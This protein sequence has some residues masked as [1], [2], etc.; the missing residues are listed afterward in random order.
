[1]KDPNGAVI[2]GAT[3]SLPARISCGGRSNPATQQCAQLTVFGSGIAL[4]GTQGSPLLGAFPI[5]NAPLP[6]SFHNL[7]S[8]VG[9]YPVSE[10]TDVYSLRLDYKFSAN[11]QLMLRGGLSPSDVTGIQVNAQNQDFGQNAFS[12]TSTQNYHDGSI[13]AQDTWILG[14]SKIN[15]LRYQYSRRG[16]LYNF[17]RRPGGGDVAVNIPGFAFFGREPFSYVNR[18]EQRHQLT[19]NFSSVKGRHNI[20]QGREQIPA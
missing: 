1:M 19:D 10:A 15:E 2:H 13:G 14:D 11:N 20:R 16:L 12:R 8:Q 17:S 4:A 5:T 6:A 3:V 7:L 18:V 9:N